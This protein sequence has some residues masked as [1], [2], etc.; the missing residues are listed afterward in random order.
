MEL[1]RLFLDRILKKTKL[2]NYLT[3]LNITYK[4]TKIYD[5]PN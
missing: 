3:G 1:S 5:T 2:F 4:K